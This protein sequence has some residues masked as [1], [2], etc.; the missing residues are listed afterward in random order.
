MELP[1]LFPFKG[2]L[3]LL[4]RSRWQWVGAGG[5]WGWKC[6]GVFVV[7]Q[8][9][10]KAASTGSMSQWGNC[11]GIVMPEGNPLPL[12]P[13]ERWVLTFSLKG[14]SPRFLV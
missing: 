11:P 7:G 12:L 3:C 13:R 10:G 4:G 1:Q 14:G 5:W 9:H 6:C 8:K 2:Y